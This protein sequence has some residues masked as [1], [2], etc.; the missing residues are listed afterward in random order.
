MEIISTP[1]DGKA[2]H[3][4]MFQIARKGLVGNLTSQWEGMENFG[5]EIFPFDGDNLLRSDFDYL[6]LFQR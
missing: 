2:K 4:R 5:G 3:A 1:R 6:N